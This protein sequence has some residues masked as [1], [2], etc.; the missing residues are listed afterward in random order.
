MNIA[1]RAAGNIPKYMVTAAFLT[2][3]SSTS[4]AFGQ[5]ITSTCF[6]LPPGVTSMPRGVL[7]PPGMALCPPTTLLPAATAPVLSATSGDNDDS[8]SAAENH[9]RS[10]LADREDR[11]V[12]AGTISGNTLNVTTIT[13]GRLKVGTQ[14]SGDGI[15]PGTRIKALG[16]GRG[17]VGTYAITTPDD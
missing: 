8:G 7:P 1:K 3:L 15:P 10:E 2:M 5:T 6:P 14:L 4:T 13:S 17:G 9:D 12:M 11:L 16:T